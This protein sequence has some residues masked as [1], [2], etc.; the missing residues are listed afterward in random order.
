MGQ[1]RSITAL[2]PAIVTLVLA[3]DPAPGCVPEQCKLPDCRC[4][5]EEIPGGLEPAKTPQI[6]LLSFDDGL[7]RQDYEGFYSK[8]FNGRKNPNGC[9][10]GLTFFASHYFTDYALLEDVS[11]LYGYEIAIH[12]VDHN[13]SSE[14]TSEQWTREVMDMKEILTKWGNV[15]SNSMLGV[16]AP[17]LATSETEM[18]VLYENKFLYEASMSTD[19]MYWPFTLDYK[20]PL[21]VAPATCPTNAYPGLWI[22]PIINL[23]QKNGFP[24]EMLDACTDPQS[25]QD[26]IDLL[27]DNFN[28][29]YNGSRAPLGI[30]SHPSWFYRGQGRDVILKTFLDNLA[31][32]PDVYVVTH[33]QMLDWVRNPTPLETIQDFAPWK[34]PASRPQPRCNYRSPRCRKWY[35]DAGY[36]LSTC[37]TPCPAKFPQTGNPDGK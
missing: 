25:A 36:P 17:F 20:S 4:A 28:A 33:I 37:T 35:A 19:I 30:Y 6:V 23:Q 11:T 13:T 32:M 3:L 7:R 27:M 9:Q 34:C 1:Y 29:H 18:G 2:L 31:A 12:T 21:C 24:C 16:R 15:P 8:V 10:I 14:T 22:V 26:W 5:S